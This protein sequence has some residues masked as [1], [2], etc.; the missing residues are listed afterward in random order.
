MRPTRAQNAEI[1]AKL[2]NDGFRVTGDDEGPEEYIKGGGPGTAGGTFVDITAKHKQTGRTV[3]VQTV[4]TLAD[5]ETP[6]PREEDA[7][8]RIQEAFP[9]DEL[10]IVPKRKMP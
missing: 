6:T 9:D 10:W 1:A 4:D 2:K 3:R 7:I 5:G 8:R